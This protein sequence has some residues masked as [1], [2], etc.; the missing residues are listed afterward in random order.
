MKTGSSGARV[1]RVIT[2]VT[3]TL[4]SLLALN[5]SPLAPLSSWLTFGHAPWATGRL[6]HV[7]LLIVLPAAYYVYWHY[8]FATAV[9]AAILSLLLLRCT[10]DQW[11]K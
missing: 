4:N 7:L 11:A 5:Y 3:T 6:A 2:Y 8:W 1:L 9:P 10:G